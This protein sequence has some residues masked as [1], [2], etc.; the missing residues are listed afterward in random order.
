[1]PQYGIH[2]VLVY[3]LRPSLALAI[4][5]SAVKCVDKFD[6]NPVNARR[7]ACH[8]GKLGYEYLD[9]LTETRVHTRSKDTRINKGFR[10]GLRRGI[11]A[12]ESRKVIDEE[13]VDIKIL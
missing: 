9:V 2:I 12:K 8:L 3:C 7:T 13:W 6:V 4:F 10:H 5:L 1:M 11:T